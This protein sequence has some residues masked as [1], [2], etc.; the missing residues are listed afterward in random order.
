[1]SP[2]GVPAIGYRWDFGD[3][4]SAQG[5]NVTHAFT[6]EAEMTIRL[7]V[8]GVDGVS[9]EKQFSLKVSGHLAV[10]PDLK[11]NRRL[12]EP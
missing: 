6:R 12:V 7:T 3:G 4:T 9:A 2:D 5:P 1:V 8:P 10:L 11:G